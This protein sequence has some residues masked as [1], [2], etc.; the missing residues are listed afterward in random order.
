MTEEN[1]YSP[2][3]S[4]IVTQKQPTAIDGY[5]KRLRVWAVQNEQTPHAMAQ[6]AGLSAGALRY[7]WK[8]KWNPTVETLRAIE[9]WMVRVE[10]AKREAQAGG[11]PPPTNPTEEPSPEE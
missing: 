6:G 3:R 2:T 11:S 5:I 9:V 4:R 8:A 7:F 10:I 1:L